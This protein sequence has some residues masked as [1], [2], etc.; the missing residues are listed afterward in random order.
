M[1]SDYKEGEEIPM[2]QLPPID[3]GS[4]SI[5]AA[6][7]LHELADEIINLKIMEVK[8]LVD[9][10]AE[11]FGIEDDVDAFGF[12]GGTGGGGGGEGGE[13]G[14]AAEEEK[15]EKTAF[16]LKLVAFDAKAK[17]KIIKEI[18]GMTSLGLK[19]AKELVEGAPKTVLKDIKME[20]ATEFKEKLEALGATVEIE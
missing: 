1:L 13:G 4:G 18:R 3:D 16:D 20:E 17:I 14:A 12:G 19:E 7:H 8:E 15:V 11:H 6:P 9:K 5:P 10:V 2:A